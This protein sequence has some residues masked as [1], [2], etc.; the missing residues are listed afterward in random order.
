M[1]VY[2]A[3]AEEFLQAGVERVFGLMGEDLAKL[4][5]E[6]DRIGI[7]YIAARHEAQAV[8]MADGYA[9]VSGKLGVVLVTSGPGFTNAL[10]LITTASNAR[11]RVIVIVG[12]RSWNE[13]E[14]EG[15]RFR[16]AKYYPVVPTRKA[17]N[18][19]A[20]KPRDAAGA[21][22]A[23]Q[24]AIA[25]ASQGETIVLNMTY[26]VLEFEAPETEEVPEAPPMAAAPPTVDPERIEIVAD[27]LQ[28]SWAISRPVILAGVGAVRSG[29]G[30]RC[31][32][33]AS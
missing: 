30:P 26:D 14:P 31:G 4:I 15:T 17:G 10:T 12:G 29:A 8:G 33:S 18:I 9:R 24:S 27:L 20:M 23:T 28:E 1:R 25:K 22:S 13:D 16:S 19:T 7:K 2:E 21:I 5:I 32:G 6:L 11:S 3:I